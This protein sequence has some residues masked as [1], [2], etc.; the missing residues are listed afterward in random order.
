MYSLQFSS[1][2][3]KMQR[4]RTF[5]VSGQAQ[6]GF[7]GFPSAPI[8]SSP[9]LVDVVF[10]DCWDMVTNTSKKTLE[11]EIFQDTSQKSVTAKFEFGELQT[12]TSLSYGFCQH[13]SW[14][15]PRQVDALTLP[16]LIVT[17]SKDAV[18]LLLPAGQ[19]AKTNLL[20]VKRVRWPYC[21]AHAL[22]Q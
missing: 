6:H 21:N 16:S 4:S 20:S 3:S 15:N 2:L 7:S 10:I 12:P 14:G 13:F 5:F 22:A 19:T 11:L 17:M 1:P 9:E 18:S 8:G